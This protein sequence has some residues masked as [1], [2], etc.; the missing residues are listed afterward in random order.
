MPNIVLCDGDTVLNKLRMVAHFMEIS[1]R[2][3]ITSFSI[4]RLNVLFC[5]K[6]T[7]VT[8]LGTITFP[9]NNVP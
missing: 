2:M 4:I 3:G 5:E 6:K 8:F 1:V 9:L 7:A